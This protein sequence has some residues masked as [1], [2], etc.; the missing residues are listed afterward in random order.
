MYIK[1]K[2]IMSGAKKLHKKGAHSV[3]AEVEN[4]GEG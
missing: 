3:C 4:G 1:N 2:R